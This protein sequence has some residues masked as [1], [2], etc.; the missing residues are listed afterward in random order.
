MKYG[1]L[2]LKTSWT[3][4]GTPNLADVYKYVCNVSGH[5]VN[6]HSTLL[7]MYVESYPTSLYEHMHTI[8]S[9]RIYLHT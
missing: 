4:E 3:V 1:A 2:K 7:Y 6:V 5:G 9:T 8:I